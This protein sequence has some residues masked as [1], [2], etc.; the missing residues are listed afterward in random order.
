MSDTQ[1]TADDP[2]LNP[3]SAKLVCQMAA[4][5]VAGKGTFS[6]ADAVTM[7]ISILHEVDRYVAPEH[8]GMRYIGERRE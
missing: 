2:V 8:Q 7:A 1:L 6:A 5:I 4:S 3:D